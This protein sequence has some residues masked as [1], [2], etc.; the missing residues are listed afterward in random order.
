MKPKMDVPLLGLS[1]MFPLLSLVF[2][3][4]LKFKSQLP[5]H[6]EHDPI[7]GKLF[8]PSPTD[9]IPHFM[10]GVQLGRQTRH[11]SFTKLM[12]LTLGKADSDTISIDML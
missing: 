9:P 4:L 11:P 8:F 5:S 3:Q 10:H 6:I 2:T 1:L 7:M 12:Q